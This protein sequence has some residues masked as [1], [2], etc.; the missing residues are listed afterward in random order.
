MNYWNQKAAPWVSMAVLMG[1]LFSAVI[2]FWVS[3]IEGR[4]YLAT[5][6]GF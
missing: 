6:N 1:G 3:N 2:L 5:I 4:M